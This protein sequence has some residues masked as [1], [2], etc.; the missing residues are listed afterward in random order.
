MA[1][2]RVWNTRS[3]DVMQDGEQEQRR[4]DPAEDPPGDSAQSLLTSFTLWL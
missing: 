3:I 2:T 1:R 4:Y